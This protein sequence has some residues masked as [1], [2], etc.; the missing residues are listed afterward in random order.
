MRC[1]VASGVGVL[2]PIACRA[3]WIRR[4]HPS[5]PCCPGCGVLLEGRQSETFG[6]GGR[7]H[8]NS[9]GRWFNYRTGTLL[10]GAIVDDRELYLLAL[11]TEMECPTGQIAAACNLSDDTVR[12]WQRRLQE[13]GR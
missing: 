4:L 13:A 2:D 6:A 11:L 9:C 5:G 3:F 1:A 8:C 12:A 10:Q 7:V